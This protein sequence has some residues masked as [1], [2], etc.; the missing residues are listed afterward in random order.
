LASYCVD[1]AGVPPGP[2]PGCW[3]CSMIACNACHAG[4]HHVSVHVQLPHSVLS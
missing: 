1:A 2:V 4:V 3:L